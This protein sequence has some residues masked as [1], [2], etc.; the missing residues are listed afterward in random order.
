MCTQPEGGI[1]RMILKGHLLAEK[2]KLSIKQQNCA[3]H[4][5][6]DLVYT[7]KA[8][9]ICRFYRIKYSFIFSVL[10]VCVCMKEPISGQFIENEWNRE[11]E[12]EE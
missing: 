5:I 8:L 2:Y 4:K 11:D 6:F 10:Y 1:F 3:F 7:L 12:R 9:E